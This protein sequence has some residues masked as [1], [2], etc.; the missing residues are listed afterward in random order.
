M[1]LY[2]S[3]HPKSILLSELLGLLGLFPANN[4]VKPLSQNY[5]SPSKKS[6]H[7]EVVCQIPMNKGNTM[8]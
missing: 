3:L 6:S 1:I 5:E 8:G 4:T 7:D 2:S